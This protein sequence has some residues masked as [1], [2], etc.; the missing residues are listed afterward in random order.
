LL[1]AFAGIVLG[2]VLFLTAPL[3]L[4]AFVGIVIIGFANAPVF[5][6]LISITPQQVGA[7]HAGNAIGFQVSAALIGSAVLPGFAGLMTDY[8]GWEVIPLLFVIESIL[9][10][11]LYLAVSGRSYA[12]A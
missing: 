3:P 7:Q 10:L 9:L 4:I 6:C 12:R 5:P 11:T 8:F 2:S 1:S